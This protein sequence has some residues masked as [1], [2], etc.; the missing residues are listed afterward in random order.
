MP[1]SDGAL[2]L[3][4]PATGKPLATALR[5]NVVGGQTVRWTAPVL[6][7]K[8]TEAIIADDHPTL[9]LVGLKKDPQPQ[10]FKVIGT[11]LEAPVAAGPVVAGASVYLVTR[12][13]MLRAYDLSGLKPAG[14]HKLPSRLVSWMG[15]AGDTALVASG[16]QLL[17][18]ASG[19]KPPWSVPLEAGPPCGVPLATDKGIVVASSGGRVMRLDAATGKLL[20]KTDVDQPL[21]AGPLPAG[22]G[23]CTVRT[24]DGCLLEIA[25]P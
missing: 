9:Y 15:A 5:P 2:M 7:P 22:E 11:G 21:V 24:A 17:G 18:T 25:I 20:G 12:D 19:K 1:V 16:S 10:L 13:G 8:G 6:S 3:L 4:D 14:E 23:A